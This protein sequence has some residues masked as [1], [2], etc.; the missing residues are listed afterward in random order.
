MASV[1][2][3]RQIARKER[4]KGPAD[5]VRRP[6]P[7][8]DGRGLWALLSAVVILS[9][10]ELCAR[11][12]VVDRAFT[13]YP[14]E[15]ARELV[16]YLS[17]STGWKDLAY[18]AKEF[19]IGFLLATL[20]G[21]PGGMVM[22]SIRRLDSA[23]DPLLNFLNASPLI[24]FA[25][26]FV[27]WFGIGMKSKVA[28]VFF[29]AVIPIIV[30]ARAGVAG[31]DRE[32]M[33]MARSWN[34][35]TLYTAR[36]VVLPG[37]VP[38]IAAGIRLGVGYALHGVV[39]GEFVAA[40]GGVGFRINAAT[41]TLDTGLMLA[42]VFLISTLGVLVTELAGVAERRFSRWRV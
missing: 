29:V 1:S 39:L 15:V 10:W 13:S 20:V 26:L 37:A 28:V 6:R 42:C 16:D 41:Q 7:I 21:I 24:A 11:T 9:S 4:H 5:K 35:G 14:S 34:A 19:A 3:E 32:L 33:T 31:A 17:S 30:S 36:T 25:P 22:G 2:A 12:G 18:T 40:Y 38:S 23:L 27:L 8:L